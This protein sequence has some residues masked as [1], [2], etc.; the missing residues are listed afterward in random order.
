MTNR[1]FDLVEKEAEWEEELQKL[2]VVIAKCE[3]VI[4]EK[5]EE[6]Q[7]ALDEVK[8]LTYFMHVFRQ[9]LGA[10]KSVLTK[11]TETSAQN[12]TI[13][14]VSYTGMTLKMAVMKIF[15]AE[16]QRR[17]TGS[18]I[19]DILLRGGYKGESPNYRTI[20]DNTLRKLV[21][22]GSIEVD[23][24]KFKHEF[25]LKEESKMKSLLN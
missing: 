25:K 3:E 1:T 14:N 6:Q 7:N 12:N 19:A 9:K 20:V 5:T 11:K 13:S 24:S 17:F 21:A 10:D 23:K 15:K 8:E 4:K 22:A 18:E 16:V 2:K